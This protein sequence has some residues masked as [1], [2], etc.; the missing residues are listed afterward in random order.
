MNVEEPDLSFEVSVI[1]DVY[2]IYAVP[3]GEKVTG[4]LNI[5]KRT[6]V[7]YTLRSDSSH[8]KFISPVIENNSDTD[9]NLT[10]T[11]FGDNNG[12][13][14]IDSDENPETIEFRLA[15][16]LRNNPDAPPII[17][18]DPQYHNRPP[19]AQ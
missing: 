4:D 6:V 11:F 7:N 13:Q 8:L 10:H 2:T 12:L 16:E 19:D 15:T 9:N 18:K 3:S 14:L 17:S 5:S 1:D